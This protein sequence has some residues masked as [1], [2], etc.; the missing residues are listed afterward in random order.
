MIPTSSPLSLESADG[1]LMKWGRAPAGAARTYSVWGVN[2]RRQ[3][4]HSIY[5]TER[6]SIPA[7]RSPELPGVPGATPMHGSCPLP[8][9][10]TPTSYSILLHPHGLQEATHPDGG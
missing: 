4:E 2:Q 9:T 5:K 3:F 8:L 1:R 6:A 10:L 7:T